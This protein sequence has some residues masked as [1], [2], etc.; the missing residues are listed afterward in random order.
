MHAILV[1]VALVALQDCRFFWWITL[2]SVKMVACISMLNHHHGN[3]MIIF[4]HFVKN[5]L[6]INIFSDNCMLYL[7]YF[8]VFLLSLNRCIV[9]LPK[10]ECYGTYGTP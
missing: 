7:L 3:F 1:V 4:S 10:L 6:N 9:N 8:F 5:M 2:Y